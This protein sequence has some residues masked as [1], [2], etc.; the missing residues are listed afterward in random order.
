MRQSLGRADGY[1]D[2]LSRE[3]LLGNVSDDHS[4]WSVH[5]N[6]GNRGKWDEG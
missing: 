6:E 4:D 5:K 1:F 3:H 2:N